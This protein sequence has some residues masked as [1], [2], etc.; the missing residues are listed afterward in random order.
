M[1][2]TLCYVSK[3]LNNIQPSKIEEI[4]TITQK[5]NSQKNI[6]GILMYG[7]GDFFQVLEGDKNTIEDLYEDHIKK[8]PRHDEIFEIIR[9]PTQ[10]PIFKEYSSLFTIVRTKKQLDDI[11][12]YLSVNKVNTTSNKLSRLL[13]PFLL[14]A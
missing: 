14:E 3:A 9:R 13:N 5:N 4:F 11:K 1:I 8:D 12:S 10:K 6:A 2:Y 7:M